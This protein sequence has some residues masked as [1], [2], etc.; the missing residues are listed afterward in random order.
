MTYLPPSIICFPAVFSPPAGFYFIQA[1]Y[2]KCPLCQELGNIK[3]F[4]FQLYMLL[5]RSTKH[6]MI[7]QELVNPTISDK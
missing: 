6:V 7:E 4:F 3:S 2:Q 1:L 5:L